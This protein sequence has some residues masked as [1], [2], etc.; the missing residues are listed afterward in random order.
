MVM[1]EWKYSSLL[2]Y[3]NINIDDMEV[4]H[5]MEIE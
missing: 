4:T 2:K 1:N 5:W 3:E